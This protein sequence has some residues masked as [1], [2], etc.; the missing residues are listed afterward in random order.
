M[1]DTKPLGRKAYGSI[2][3]LP[4]SR[5]G[6]GDHACHPGQK[7][8]ATEKVRDRHDLVY[9]QEK[10]D[11]SCTAVAKV[12]GEIIALG[13]AGWRADSSPYLQHVMF[14][15]WVMAN[16]SRF[17]A[18]LNEGERVV[19]EWLA[20]A[21]GTRYDLT[22]REPWVPFDIMR[23]TDRL[24]V[25]VTMLRTATVGFASPALLAVGPTT[26]EAAMARLGE[27]G[28]Y[29]ALDP[30]EGVVWRVERDGKVD[31]LLK[32]VRPEKVDGCYLESQTN[33]EAIWNWQP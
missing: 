19:G 14:H 10:L 20:Q 3:H 15:D 7:V 4:G 29:G 13:R 32:Y 18:L 12:S 23:E 28:H 17:D 22:G 8:I 9:V 5:M 1:N 6:P 11:G 33:A 2:A 27:F 16:R 30:A 31:Y 21:H 26:I 25:Y 24:P